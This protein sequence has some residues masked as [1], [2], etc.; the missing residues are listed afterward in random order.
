MTPEAVS[1]FPLLSVKGDKTCPPIVAGR[2]QHFLGKWKQLTHDPSILNAVRGY[3]IDFLLTPVQFTIPRPINFSAQESANV[4]AQISKFLEKGIIVQSSH[5]EGEF[6]SNIFLRPKK[7]GSFRM[8]LNLKD[9]NTFVRFHHFKMDSIHTCSQLMRPCCYMASIDL[10]DAYYSVPIAKEHQKYLKFIWQGNLYQFTCLA[11]GLSSAP[12]LF[13]KL[14]KPVFSFLRELGHFSS[15]YLDDSF[16]L[17]YSI[18]E[19]QANIYDTLTLYHELGFL[20]HEVKSVT[21]PTQ[22]LHHLGFILNSLDMTV[23][24]SADKHQKL[25][26][27]AQ[28]ILDSQ[29]PTIREVAQLIGMMVSCF[30]GVEYGELFYRQLE[31]EKLRL[32]KLTTGILNKLCFYPSWHLQIF[33]GGSG[34]F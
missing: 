29:S 23:S 33:L 31:I 19:C 30:P 27:A 22:V 24:I 12:R 17:G 21:I 32:L 14:M 4:N 3:K 11:Q 13:T 6:I 25:K 16:L 26:L 34:M 7:D 9:L 18:D 5:E 10:R 15:G 1:K 2:I 20:P 8:I 28:R